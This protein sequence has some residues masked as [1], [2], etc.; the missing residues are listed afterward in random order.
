[1]PWWASLIME[2]FKLFPTVLEYIKNHGGTKSEAI[3]SFSESVK[4]L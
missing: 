3:K 2:L 1:M 4:E